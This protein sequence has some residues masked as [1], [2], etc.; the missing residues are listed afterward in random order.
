MYFY[1][2]D[3]YNKPNDYKNFAGYEYTKLFTFFRGLYGG[4]KLQNHALNSRVNSEFRNKISTK[5]DIEL[6]VINGSKYAL[7]ISYLYVEGKDISKIA[8]K[9]VNEYIYL[10]T[11]KDNKLISDIEELL[12]METEENKKR[13]ICDMLDENSEARVFEII[14]YSILKSYYRNI[15]IYFGYTIDELQERYLEL[16]K[17][18]RTNANDG[19]IDFV[20]RPLGR[21][22]Q[23]TE[24]NDYNKYLLDIDKVMHFPITFVI[25]TLQ[26]NEEV[27]KAFKE[28]IEHK[29]GGMK[30]IKERYIDAI[31][32]I[33]TINELKARLF[34]L[35]IDTVNE[36]LSD[37]DKYYRIELNIP[38]KQSSNNENA[39]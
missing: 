4:E 22:F 9:I 30:V 6:I 27:E 21:F 34:E 37:I 17:T 36:L 15:K 26:K 8:N 29:S 10:L 13:K 32:E 20:M 33:I 38:N 1:E 16:Y 24:V 5:H 11:I 3:Y 35:N 23:V 39:H 28:Y 18:G 2:Q 12:L 25:K 14:S 7:N 19:G 31:E